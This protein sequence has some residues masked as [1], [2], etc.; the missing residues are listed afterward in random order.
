[1]LEIRNVD[2]VHPVSLSNLVIPPYLLK[3][4]D[5]EWVLKKTFLLLILIYLII[6]ILG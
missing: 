1:M 2:P 3:V 5:L 6:D 4:S